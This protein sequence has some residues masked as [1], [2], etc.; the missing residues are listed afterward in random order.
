VLKAKGWSTRQ[1]AD[2]TGWDHSTIV[3]DFAGE[4]SPKGGEKSPGPAT[5]GGREEERGEIAAA[6]QQH[7]TTDPPVGKYRIVY[8]DPPWSYGNTQPDYHTE[9]RDHYP[10]MTLADICALHWVPALRRDSAE[11]NDA[12]WRKRST[13]LTTSS[14]RSASEWPTSACPTASSNTSAASAK[15]QFPNI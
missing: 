2:R 4:K 15:T 9:Q 5:T 1:I 7:G 10:V 13:P 11:R 14:P 6:A 8:A 3:K 12:T